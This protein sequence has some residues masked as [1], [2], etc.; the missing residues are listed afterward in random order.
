METGKEELAG[1][2]IARIEGIMEEMRTRLNHL[3][4]NF[5]TL[6]YVQIGAWVTL[7]AAIIITRF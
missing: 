4:S 3:E 6:L 7:M 5:R 1:E 2:R